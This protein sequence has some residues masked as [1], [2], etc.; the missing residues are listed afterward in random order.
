MRRQ[1][2]GMRVPF[3]GWLIKSSPGRRKEKAS[4]LQNVGPIMSESAS[5]YKV[6]V[7]Q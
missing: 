5:R 4:S 2:A 7:L 3:K 1:R 6:V